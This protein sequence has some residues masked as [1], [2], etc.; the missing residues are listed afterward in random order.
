MSDQPDGQFRGRMPGQGQPSGSTGPTARP[1]VPGVP[2]GGGIPARIFGRDCHWSCLVS[3]SVACSSSSSSFRAR[4]HSAPGSPSAVGLALL[5]ASVVNRRTWQLYAG[6]IVTAIEPADAPPGSPRDPRGGRA[7]ERCSSASPCWRSRW[8]GWLPGPAGAGS[9]I[10]GAILRVLGCS[11]S[12]A[13]IAGFPVPGSPGLAGADPSAG[14]SR[15]SSG[16]PVAGARRAASRDRVRSRPPGRAAHRHAAVAVGRPPGHAG[17]RPAAA[18]SSR[19]EASSTMS[20]TTPWWRS[21]RPEESARCS[22][23]S[24]GPRTLTAVPAGTRAA[25]S[26]TNFAKCSNR[27]TPAS[28]VIRRHRGASMGPSRTC[29]VDDHE[30]HVENHPFPRATSSTTSAGAPPG[31]RSIQH[32]VRISAPSPGARDLTSS[33]TDY[34]SYTSLRPAS[35]RARA[36]TR[37]R[38]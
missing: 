25:T 5:I 17:R 9:S 33:G 19:S 11:S 13:R 22:R 28:Y 8:R 26:P 1:A 34:L 37:R 35:V 18:G 6:A 32:H 31:R 30:P 29:P 10:V 16:A 27:L 15:S 24:P 21:L 36:A 12:R 23:V 20:R 14:R 38:R 2:T 3:S 4:A 7:G